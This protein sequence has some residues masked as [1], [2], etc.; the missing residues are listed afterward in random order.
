MC[1]T[2]KK[3][4]CGFFNKRSSGR[5]KISLIERCIFY[6]FLQLRM[7]PITLN[8]VYVNE[9]VCV[10]LLKPKGK[11]DYICKV[12]SEQMI[13]NVNRGKKEKPSS[14]F[15]TPGFSIPCHLCDFKP[16]KVPQYPLASSP[17]ESSLFAVCAAADFRGKPWRTKWLE[18]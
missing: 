8:E 14:G 3:Q 4:W 6:T 7:L 12:K 1:I 15:L 16:Q 18:N 5:K 2:Y 11:L 10:C 9:W 13:Q 17:L